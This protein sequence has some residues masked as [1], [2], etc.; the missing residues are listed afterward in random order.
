MVAVVIVFATA[1][2]GTRQPQAAAPLWID[3]TAA[4]IGDPKSD[5]IAAKLPAAART[6]I[7]ALSPGTAIRAA[8]PL[9]ATATKCLTQ[10]ARRSAAEPGRE[11]MRCTSATSSRAFAATQSRIRKSLSA[12]PAHCFVI[13]A[14]SPI[15]LATKFISIPRR[16]KLCAITRRKSSGAGNIGQAGNRK[17]RKVSQ[18]SVKQ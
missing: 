17:F 2:T 14:T 9:W 13:S 4:T 18:Y 1:P 12:R 5:E 8:C 3:I 15:A 16:E 6:P 11:V 7:Q 10:K